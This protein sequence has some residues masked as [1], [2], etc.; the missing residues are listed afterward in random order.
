MTDYGTC[1]VCD[2]KIT[3]LTDAVIMSESGGDEGDPEDAGSVTYRHS[4]C[5]P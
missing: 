1:P 2:M 5:K 4:N 3:S